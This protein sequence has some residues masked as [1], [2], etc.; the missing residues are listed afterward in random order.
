MLL[1]SLDDYDKDVFAEL[2]KGIQA[3]IA[4]S[5]E[6]AAAVGNKPLAARTYSAQPATP[7][8]SEPP[9]AGDFAEFADDDIPF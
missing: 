3:M 7:A 8:K 9:T 6:Y 1:L 5:P 4:N 2:P